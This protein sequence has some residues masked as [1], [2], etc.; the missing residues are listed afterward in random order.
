MNNFTYENPVKIVFGKGSIGELKSLIKRGQKVMV[1]YG[2]GSIKTNGVYGQVME[3]LNNHEVVEFGGIEANPEYET[4][5]KGVELAKSE[6]VDFLL[7]VGG[8]SVLD[9]TK[10]MAVAIPWKR[11]DPWDIISR[12]FPVKE[13]I[14]LASVM[15]LA[16]TGSEMN[17]LAVIS[18]REMGVKQAFSSPTCYPQFSILDPETTY[19]LPERQ[20]NNG[21]VDTFVH[22]MEQ[23]LTVRESSPLQ[24]RQA[25]AILKTL[26]E[27][28]PKVKEN[29]HDYDVKA[30]FVWCATQALNGLIGC[31][32][33]Q[34]WASHMIGHE[35]TALYGIDHGQVLAVML[36]AVLKHQKENKL[37]KLVQYGEK[38]WNITDGFSED[39]A[40]KAIEKTVGFFKSL[41]VKTTLKEY[42]IGSE[43]FEKI[44]NIFDERK[45]ELGEKG[46]IKGKEVVEILELCL[47]EGI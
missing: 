3:G 40:D 27:E 23:Y 33:P 12:G 37:E 31:G 29:P 8:G 4:L 32:V 43:N 9:G 22:V 2:G 24:D 36:P 39:R 19:S 13:A 28:A 41:G 30:N 26:I 47:G 10:F 42:E 44:G 38:V 17:C 46:V 5:M 11:K 25:E 20:I 16:G 15:T 1:T 35:L 14:P 18:R 6:N 34:D 7:A 21:I 45:M